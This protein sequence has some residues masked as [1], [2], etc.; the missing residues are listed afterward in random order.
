VDQRQTITNVATG[1]CLPTVGSSF[2]S[3]ILTNA[4]ASLTYAILGENPYPSSFRI[5]RTIAFSP[6]AV[7]SSCEIFALDRDCL[8]FRP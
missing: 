7:N 8:P 4:T 1:S 5:H 6:A 3:F 2:N